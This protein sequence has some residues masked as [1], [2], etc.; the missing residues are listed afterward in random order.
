MSRIGE[1]SLGKR[2][3][4]GF[5]PFVLGEHQPRPAPEVDGSG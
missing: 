1:P 2:G 4:L 5:E 3:K